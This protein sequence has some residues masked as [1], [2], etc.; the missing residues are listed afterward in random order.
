M[1]EIIHRGW[2]GHHFGEIC[3]F[4]LNSLVTHGEL[5]IV[6]STVGMRIDVGSREIVPLY[7]GTGTFF[8]TA[9]FHADEQDPPQA[10]I[11]ARIDLMQMRERDQV[12]H[13]VFG[14][15][16]QFCHQHLVTL[17]HENILQMVFD[18]LETGERFG[19]FANTPSTGYDW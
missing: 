19:N 18:L 11:T 17:S 2:Q 6:V 9:L 7:P 12:I 5:S 13:E 10:R 14:T 15:G 16:T 4:H 3:R 1:S 8:E